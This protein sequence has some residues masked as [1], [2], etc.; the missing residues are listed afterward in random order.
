[1]NNFSFY[2]KQLTKILCLALVSLTYS[3]NDTIVDELTSVNFKRNFST[4]GIDLEEGQTSV[5]I[6]W[7]KALNSPVNTTYTIEVANDVNF[8]NG[9]EKSFQANTNSINLLD[10]D[11]EV[12]KDYYARVKTNANEGKE[13]SSWT[14]SAKFR[15]TG[16]QYLEAIKYDDIYSDEVT[17]KWD[18][19]KEVTHLTINGTRIDLSPTDITAGKKVITGLTAATAYEVIIWDGAA[20]KGARTFTTKLGTPTGNRIDVAASDD[21]RLKIQG[22]AGGGVF[23]LPQGANFAR[24]TSAIAIPAGANITIYGEE[25]PNKPVINLGNN[26]TLPAGAAVGQIRFENV[27]IDGAGSN[28]IINTTAGAANTVESIIFENCEIRNFNAAILRLQSNASNGPKTVTNIIFNHCI[29]SDINVAS[30]NYAVIDANSS[31]ADVI[32]IS[33]IEMKNSTF[34][35]IGRGL[36]RYDNNS[37]STNL[38][39]EDCTIYNV[40]IDENAT[41]GNGNRFLFD[42]G[43][44]KPVVSTIKNVIAAKTINANAKGIRT[45][46][47]TYT[48]SNSYRTSDYVVVAN[49]LNFTSY[50]KSSVDLFLAPES[51]DFRIKDTE[52]V[53]RATAGD[54]RWR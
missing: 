32:S 11:I 39:L 26:F 36:V 19:S 28:Y 16:A 4:T 33:N 53:G 52:F 18:A 6:K 44:T 15:I 34:Y 42:Y 20:D 14:Y 9:A 25:G 40:G 46:A 24:N 31:T 5:L 29:V 49:Q 38:L 48:A 21:L 47:S 50:A 13:E 3:C 23:V 10:T 37:A 2:K 51:G 45:G 43:A 1:M 8:S 17:I 22:E 35:N 54:P 30:N 7:N 12:R 27:I 41:P